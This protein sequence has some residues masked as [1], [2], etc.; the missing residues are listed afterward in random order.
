MGITS[1]VLLA[2][3]SKCKGWE[4]LLLANSING[5]ADGGES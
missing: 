2:Q 4:I 1:W 3:K 5:Q